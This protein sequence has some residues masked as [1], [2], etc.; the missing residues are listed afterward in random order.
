VATAPPAPP[1][2]PAPN[3]GELRAAYAA[4]I[5]RVV[6]EHRRYPRLARRR[7][8]QGRILVA[9]VVAS[10]GRLGAPPRIAHSPGYPALE[11]E[12]LRM[13]RAAAPYPPLPA[14]LDEMRLMV[15]VDFSLR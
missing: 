4:R 7:H 1:P 5:A 8:R 3:K 14:P 6:A 12:A 11:A 9:L 2:A 13:V 15:P 10:D